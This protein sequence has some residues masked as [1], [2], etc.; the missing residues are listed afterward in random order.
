MDTARI[1]TF[2][3]VVEKRSFNRA[4]EVLFVTPAAVKKQMDTL[5]AEVGAPL[6]LRTSSGC[7]CTPAGE[8]F[9][10]HVRRILHDIQAA[11]VRD[12]AEDRL[13][14]LRMG[15]TVKLKY[16]FASAMSDGYSEQYA[17]RQL[18]QVLTRRQRMHADLK[19]SAITAC[20]CINPGEGVPSSL[21]RTKVGVTRIYAAMRKTHPLST[22]RH[23]AIRD[24]M[25][26]DCY[27]SPL[28]DTPIFDALNAR[29]GGGTYSTEVADRNDIILALSHNAVV[30]W[31]CSV[32][33]NV[34]V[35]LDLPPL[36]IWLYYLESTPAIKDL[37]AY[38]E[39][40]FLQSKGQPII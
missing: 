5:E 1:E 10:R 2:L 9:E 25:P 14:E 28:L 37:V 21:T 35:P 23:I 19:S 17:G 30:L 20:L 40:L 36:D 34:S 29:V 22:R 6:L 26:Y 38:L 32:D 13:G 18:R 16:R 31:P 33:N 7:V 3:T 39:N 8:V 24:L 12:A 11:E 15:L 27:V 4:A